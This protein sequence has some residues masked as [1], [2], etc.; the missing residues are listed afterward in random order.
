MNSVEVVSHQGHIQ[1][2]VS[3]KAS[4]RTVGLEVKRFGSSS[5]IQK[6][7]NPSLNSFLVTQM[8]IVVIFCYVLLLAL[9]LMQFITFFTSH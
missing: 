5:S 1:E 2:K 7:K 8:C 6:L 9:L 4:G 3:K